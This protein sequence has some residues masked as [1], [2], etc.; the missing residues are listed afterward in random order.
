MLFPLP[1]IG[2]VSKAESDS[3]TDLDQCACLKTYMSW[4]S[5]S[6]LPGWSLL[7]SD[8]SYPEGLVSLTALCKAESERE[9]LINVVQSAAQTPMSRIFC[10]RPGL[11]TA[12]VCSRYVAAQCT[13]STIQL[14]C[15][16]VAAQCQ[17]QTLLKRSFSQ[18]LAC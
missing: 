8:L 18:F 4:I 7:M 17:M 16:Y 12:R 14:Q 5:N 11:V 13:F 2:P 6:K 3:V 9:I 1:G 10:S 15:R